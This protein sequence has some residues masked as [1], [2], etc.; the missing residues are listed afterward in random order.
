[1]KP[2]ES[3]QSTG[4]PADSQ[5]AAAITALSRDSERSGPRVQMVEEKAKA[6]F[7]LLNEDE[8]TMRTIKIPMSDGARRAFYELQI[9]LIL[10]QFSTEFLMYLYRAMKKRCGYIRRIASK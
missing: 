3:P 1:M 7:S 5:A 4:P 10:S 2:T 9:S 8:L 6:I